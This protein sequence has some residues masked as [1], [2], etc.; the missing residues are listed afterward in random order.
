MRD[1]TTRNRSV[2][3]RGSVLSDRVGFLGPSVLQI[4][5]RRVTRYGRLG[6]LIPEGS[7]QFA[8]GK[9]SPTTEE[10]RGPAG[11]RVGSKRCPQAR[12]VPVGRSVSV[13]LPWR[14]LA[15]LRLAGMPKVC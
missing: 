11:H 2:D 4:R 15:M 6:H 13:L 8:G 3:F 7:R 1:S 5:L 10:V 12:S 14:D 9:R